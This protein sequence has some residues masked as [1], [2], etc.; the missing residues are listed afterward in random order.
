LARRPIYR[1]LLLDPAGRTRPRRSRSPPRRRLPD[2]TYNARATLSVTAATAS[3]HPAALPRRPRR[4][5]GGARVEHLGSVMLEASELTFAA[6][7]RGGL[8]VRQHGALPC[9]PSRVPTLTSDTRSR[10]LRPAPRNHSFGQPEMPEAARPTRQRPRAE[11][12]VKDGPRGADSLPA[13]VALVHIALAGHFL[14]LRGLLHRIWPLA[15]HARYT[16]GQ[17][18]PDRPRSPD[19]ARVRLDDAGK[20]CLLDRGSEDG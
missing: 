16:Q 10:L 12:V 14:P 3:A 17:T 5:D 20:V 15:K 2:P 13:S 4:K 8:P 9:G 19:V 7:V 11:A 18:A 6:S 1:R